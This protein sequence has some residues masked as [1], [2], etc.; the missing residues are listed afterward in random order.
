M[1]ISINF[2]QLSTFQ[3]IEQ[4]WIILQVNK[5][6]V[7]SGKTQAASVSSTSSIT[8]SRGVPVNQYSIALNQNLKQHDARSLL[9]S[10]ETLAFLVR[11]LAHITPHNFESCVHGIRTFVEASLNGGHHQVRHSRPTSIREGKRSKKRKEEKMKK[12]K[13]SPSHLSNI[14]DSDEEKE[15]TDGYHSLSLQVS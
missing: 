12:S 7:E 5:D 9:K 1:D 8:G 3:V 11:D 6:E 13:S 15:I 2:Q 14:H 4:V 10:C